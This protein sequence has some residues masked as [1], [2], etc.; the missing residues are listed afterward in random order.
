[1][2]R[3]VGVRGKINSRVQGFS[4]FGGKSSRFKIPLTFVLS[5]LGRGP[6]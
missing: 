2:L 1:M 4:A 6:G 3:R 5:P